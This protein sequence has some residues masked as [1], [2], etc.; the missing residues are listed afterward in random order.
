M[1]PR[2]TA[3]ASSVR[4]TRSRRWV[5]QSEVSRPTGQRLASRFN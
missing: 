4:V 3:K 5:M 2:N 1:R